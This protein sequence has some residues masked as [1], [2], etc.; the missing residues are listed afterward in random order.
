[1]GPLPQ[2]LGGPEEVLTNER[3]EERNLPRPANSAEAPLEIAPE[4]CPD[5]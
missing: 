4:T 1:M 5:A 3:G 2:K